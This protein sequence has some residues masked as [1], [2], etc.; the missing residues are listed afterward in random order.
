MIFLTPGPLASVVSGLRTCSAP[1]HLLSEVTQHRA[2]YQADNVSSFLKGEKRSAA[3][4]QVAGL[5]ISET[6]GRNRVAS[7]EA[8]DSVTMR[9]TTLSVTSQSAVSTID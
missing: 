2:W 7:A 6:G 1:L 9:I 3:T 8:M 5:L 4:N